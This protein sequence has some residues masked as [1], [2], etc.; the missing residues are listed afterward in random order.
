MS[1]A[2]GEKDDRAC[3]QVPHGVILDPQPSGTR[4]DIDRF[5]VWMG[6]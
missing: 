4:E 6:V 2:D 5:F 1:H 3:P